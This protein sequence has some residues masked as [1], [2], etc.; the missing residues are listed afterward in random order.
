[1][2]IRGTLFSKNYFASIASELYH[3]PIHFWSEEIE[4]SLKIIRSTGSGAD[5]TI[6]SSFFFPHHIFFSASKSGIEDK[7]FRHRI[8][9]NG[10]L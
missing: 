10:L 3:K 8:A 7:L 2:R 4:S 9:E 1:M 5:P 6:L